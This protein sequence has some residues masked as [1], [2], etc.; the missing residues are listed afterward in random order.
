M[1]SQINPLWKDKKIG[2]TN[3][4]IGSY[5]CKISCY[6]YLLGTT[7]D[8][9]ASCKEYFNSDGLLISDS[10]VANDFGG[11]F[12]SNRTNAL[13]D[14]VV[15]EVKY[16]WKDGHQ[17]QHFVVR[18]NG[19]IL[20]PL[21]LDGHP[22]QDYKIISY[23][24]I[25]K[26]KQE[27]DVTNEKALDLM[28]RAAINQPA[29]DETIPYYKNNV[30][31][32]AIDVYNGNV[33]PL[34]DEISRLNGVVNQVNQ[35]KSTLS[36]NIDELNVQILNLKNELG[37]T[38]DKDKETIDDLTKR[39]EEAVNQSQTNVEAYEAKIKDLSNQP[40]QIVEKVVDHSIEVPVYQTITDADRR[41]YA[42]EYLKDI[43][44]GFFKRK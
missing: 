16:T 8:V 15:C 28:R 42:I 5:G 10:Q 24:N 13:H 25:W 37:S 22:A 2:S 39:L 31:Q 1:I 40:P 4:T 19:K 26:D 14:P 3:L 34:N 43:I 7:P 41:S 11:H 33:K 38:E 12:D 32:Y 17:T 23:R 30:D 36:G 21:T 35:E 9:I 44:K 18:E 20:D 29:G 27:D 6:S